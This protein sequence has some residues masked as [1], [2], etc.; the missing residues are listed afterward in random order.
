MWMAGNYMNCAPSPARDHRG[1][2]LD[3]E[4][5]REDEHGKDGQQGGEHYWCGA[6]HRCGG[7]FAEETVQPAGSVMK[8]ADAASEGV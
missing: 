8:L 5:L 2:Q 3:T 4:V 1:E 6:W 7:G